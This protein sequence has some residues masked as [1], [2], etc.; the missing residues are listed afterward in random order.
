M[1]FLGFS[2][3]TQQVVNNINIRDAVRE[4]IGKIRI[5]RPR[6]QFSTKQESHCTEK[7]LCIKEFLVK[8]NTLIMHNLIKYE[9]KF[10]CNHKYNKTGKKRQLL[11]RKL[12]YCVENCTSV[13][14]TELMCRKLYY[15]VED[16]TSVQKTELLCRKLY[17]CLYQFV[18]NCTSVQ[19]TI[20]C[21]G[22]KLYYC[23]ENC[24][25]VQKTVLLC[26]RLYQ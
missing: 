9:N 16:C 24:T 15:C 13:Q 12:Y 19:K 26:R 11:A 17:W 4:N 7:E 5:W 14:K 8:N 2:R 22:R 1:P 25:I 23:V 18:E 6:G 3:G 21:V 10:L 20:Q